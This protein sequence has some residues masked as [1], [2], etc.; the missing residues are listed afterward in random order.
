MLLS[1]ATEGYLLLKSTSC[2][3]ETIVTDRTKLR[4]FQEFVGDIDVA[5]VTPEHVREFL[6]HERARDLSPYTVKRQYASLSAFYTWCTDPEIDLADR[7][8]TD[9]VPPPKLPKRTTMPVY[10]R[11]DVEALLQATRGTRCARRD[12]SL[13]LSLL[14]SCCRASELAGIEVSH[15]HWRTGRISVTG[16]GSKQ[17]FVSLGQRALAA[18]FLYVRQARPEPVRGNFVYLTIHGNPMTRHSI[19]HAIAKLGKRAGVHANCHKFRHTGLLERLRGG[20][21]LMTLRDYAGHMDVAVSQ[22]YLTALNADDVQRVA[23][24]TSVV[25][26]WGL[27]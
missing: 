5:Q 10:S 3:P 9:T 12:K 27:G 25:D 16:K 13:V 23:Q 2:S 6:A 22:K 11:D 1:D 20:M 14:D 26:R 24:R 18:L 21:D 17:R 15:V 19:Y 8:P 4:Q 7:D